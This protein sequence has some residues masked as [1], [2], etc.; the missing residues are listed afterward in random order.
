VEF[1][2]M[3]I[4]ARNQHS[5]DMTPMSSITLPALLEYELEVPKYNINNT[6]FVALDICPVSIVTETMFL[7][8][9]VDVRL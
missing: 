5:H 3:T 9:A 2:G 7:C 6:R 8:V 1:D 4:N